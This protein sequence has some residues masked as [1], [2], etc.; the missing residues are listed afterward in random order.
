MRTARVIHGSGSRDLI[1]YLAVAALCLLA[2]AGCN[3]QARSST[4]PVKA[5]AFTSTTPES[6]AE[7]RT[8][9]MSAA[10]A[11]VS[12][13][14]QAADELR[15]RTTRNDVAEWAMQQRILLALAC[16]TNA[17]GSNSYVALLDTM[18]LVVLTRHT[19]EEY[20]IPTLLHEEGAPLLDACRHGEHHVWS[21]G[22]KVLSEPQLAE[23][24]RVIDDWRSAN[25]T[26]HLVSHVRFTDFARAMRVTP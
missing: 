19:L 23:L 13:V 2:S 15:A 17:S 7:A 4:R 22:A 5:S 24:R 11:Y 3:S 14:A 21:L 8:Q 1:T 20:W 18:A 26:Q 9:A 12:I 16:Y 6:L 10:D 25:P